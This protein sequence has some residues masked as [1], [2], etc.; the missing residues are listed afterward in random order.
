[1]TPLKN[2]GSAAV[3]IGE[4][5]ATIAIVF[6]A[7]AADTWI[8]AQQGTL[9]LFDYE[10]EAKKLTFYTLGLGTVGVVLFIRAASLYRADRLLS[11]IFSRCPLCFGVNLVF[12]VKIATLEDRVLCRDCQAQWGV[13]LDILSGELDRLWL[14]DRGIASG[15]QQE[16]APST[17]DPEQWRLWAKER[18]R[19]KQGQKT[20]PPTPQGQSFFCPLCG[21]S[22]S[23]DAKFCSACGNELQSWRSS[24]I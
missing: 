18:H 23:P 21:H 1:M 6:G 8:K 15:E 13:H 19:H 22:N 11:E 10:G 9:W 5:F 12:D 14:I 24:K 16:A 7:Q 4:V 17:D 3:I 2:W 20:I